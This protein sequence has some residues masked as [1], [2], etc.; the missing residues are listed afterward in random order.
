MLF[1]LFSLS[2]LGLSYATPIGT[3]EFIAYGPPVTQPAKGAIWPL[4]SNQS[5]EWDI[6]TIPKD[7][8]NH[9]VQILLG[10][11]DSNSEHLDIGKSTG[12]S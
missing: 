1:A 12:F 3:P 2:L 9:T 4:G 6:G 7:A 5:V 10:R 11:P 8:Q